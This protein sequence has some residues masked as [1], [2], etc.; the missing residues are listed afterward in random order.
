MD[1]EQYTRN[2][3]SRASNT[4]YR[5]N[6]NQLH[7]V[8]L[9]NQVRS[10]GEQLDLLKKAVFYG[11][12][13]EDSVTGRRPALLS[14]GLEHPLPELSANQIDL[15]H[16]ILGI[17]TES[18]ELISGWLEAHDM[19]EPLD[20]VNMQEELGD[21]LW[22]VVLAASGAGASLDMLMQQNDAKLEARYGAVFSED[23]ANNRDLDKER[24]ILER[25]SNG[26]SVEEDTRGGGTQEG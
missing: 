15:F 10:A 25:N 12:V 20:L 9:L 23:A 22:Y 3:K 14:G 26:R 24:E 16:G 19:G 18:S 4:Y 6:G 2:V 1:T 5:E 17:I 8:R 13:T 11:K 7:L 21:V